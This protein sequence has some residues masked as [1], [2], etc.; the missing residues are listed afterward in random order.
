MRPTLAKWETVSGRSGAISIRDRPPV[1]ENL[2]RNISNVA[3]KHP[4]DHVL[5]FPFEHE[6]RHQRIVGLTILGAQHRRMTQ[7]ICYFGWNDA[8]QV[9]PSLDASEGSF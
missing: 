6:L 4:S 9:L 3:H 1:P 2:P 7:D 8:R 5:W